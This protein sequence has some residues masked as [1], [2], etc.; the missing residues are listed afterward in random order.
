MF[1][2]LAKVAKHNSLQ[3]PEARGKCRGTQLDS[4]NTIP[5][6]DYFVLTR[7]VIR[8]TPIP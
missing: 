7:V 6:T 2:E 5:S 1:D 8:A 3:K 4:C